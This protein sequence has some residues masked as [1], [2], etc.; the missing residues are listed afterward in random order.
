M[1]ELNSISYVP[2]QC[3]PHLSGKRVLGW[4]T[5]PRNEK[6][7]RHPLNSI[8]GL[9]IIGFMTGHKGWTSTAKM[10]RSQPDLVQA[11][12]WTHKT[13]P[14]SATIH[15]VLKILDAD[16]V[17]KTFT[18]WV[19]DVCKCQSDLAG[20]LDAVAIDGKTMRAS[21]KCGAAISH[22]PSVVSYELRVT[23]TQQGVSDKTN[24]IPISTEILENFDVSGKVITTDAFLTQKTFCQEIIEGNGDYV[25]PVKN[26]H[27]DD[28][29]DDIQ[30]LFQDVPDTL[31]ED[32]THP[33]LEDPITLTRLMKI[34]W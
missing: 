9:N 5:D 27:P 19:E 7:K 16:A 12:G 6:G 10:A 17:E 4:R 13:S 22:L 3:L 11:F 15:N 28:L 8:L 26:N 33:L 2:I 24:E 23:R 29:C 14:C 30:K 21:K 1:E 31:S 18:N 25:L 20:S 32:A 34:T